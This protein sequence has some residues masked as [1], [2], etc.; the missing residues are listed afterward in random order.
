METSTI[1]PDVA[2]H[3]IWINRLDLEMIGPP[4]E[5][6]GVRIVSSPHGV[7]LWIDDQREPVMTTADTCHHLMIDSVQECP[8]DARVFV[9]GLGLGLVLLYLEYSRKA[10]EVLVCEIDPRVIWLMRDC[11]MRTVKTPLRIV[12]GDAA[13]EI[14]KHGL[15]DWVYIDLTEECNGFWCPDS[16]IAPCKAALTGR[17]VFTPQKIE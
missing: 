2:S 17:G 3:P 8:Q 5:K 10:K 16:M 12:L 14:K 9:S 11:V 1:L 6:D 13:D 4:R 7:D 15:F